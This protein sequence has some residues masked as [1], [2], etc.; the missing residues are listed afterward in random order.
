MRAPLNL[1]KV[2]PLDSGGVEVDA[3]LNDVRPMASAW[4][5]SM[6]MFEVKDDTEVKGGRSWRFWCR[7]RIRA[8]RPHGNEAQ[9]SGVGSE[10]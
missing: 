1:I 6:G 10:E 7:S 2:A 5:C 8:Q 3:E 4:S 9:V